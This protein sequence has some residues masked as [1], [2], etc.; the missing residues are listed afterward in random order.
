MKILTPEDARDHMYSYHFSENTPV[1]ILHGA[2][3]KIDLL[4][5]I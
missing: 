4:M 5:K 2:S 3:D 1:D